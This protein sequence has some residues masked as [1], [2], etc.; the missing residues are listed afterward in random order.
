MSRLQLYNVSTGFV[1]YKIVLYLTKISMVKILH[2]AHC[3]HSHN[4]DN[5]RIS[6]ADSQMNAS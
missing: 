4:Y 3:D 5:H 6:T 1:G 2:A